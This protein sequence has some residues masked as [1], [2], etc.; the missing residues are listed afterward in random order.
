MAEPV[1][2]AAH[3]LITDPA[4]GLVCSRHVTEQMLLDWGIIDALPVHIAGEHHDPSDELKHHRHVGQ[5]V[6]LGHVRHCTTPDHIIGR[7]IPT[8]TDEFH[9]ATLA[10]A[11]SVARQYG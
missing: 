4:D 3:D 6:G 11:N 9:A 10:W 8:R 5:A 7:R 1:D 2:V